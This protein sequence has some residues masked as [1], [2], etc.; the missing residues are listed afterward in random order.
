[1]TVLDLAWFVG[2]V[3][4]Y[5]ILASVGHEL[6]HA[7]TAR[8]VGRRLAE[9]DLFG[10]HVDW[11]IPTA[12]PNWRDRLIGAAPLLVALTLGLGA[13][14][15]GWTLTPPQWIAVGVLGLYGGLADLRVTEYRPVPAWWRSAAGGLE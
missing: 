5:G 8:L 7:I 12:G 6:T 9:V 14:L 11:V 4:G 1:M 13:L 10:N 3:V 2:R 15:A